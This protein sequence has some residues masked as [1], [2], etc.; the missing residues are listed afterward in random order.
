MKLNTEICTNIRQNRQ[1]VFFG[2]KIEFNLGELIVA[3]ATRAHCSTSAGATHSDNTNNNTNNTNNNTNNTNNTNNNTKNNKQSENSGEQLR[4]V[5]HAIAVAA[6]LPPA[7]LSHVVGERENI[8]CADSLDFDAALWQRSVRCGAATAI[9]VSIGALL[10]LRGNLSVPLA[11]QLASAVCAES[12]RRATF[13]AGCVCVPMVVLTSHLAFEWF[14]QHGR[15]RT[16][17]LAFAESESSPATT[18]GNQQKQKK[19]VEW[20]GKDWFEQTDESVFSSVPVFTNQRDCEQYWAELLCAK[21]SLSTMSALTNRSDDRRRATAYEALAT[22]MDLM[23]RG[24]APLPI[25]RRLIVA[26]V[27][28]HV[29]W[30]VFAN[31]ALA[32]DEFLC[33][34][35]GRVR[36]VPKSVE[37]RLQRHF[38]FGMELFDEHGDFLGGVRQFHTDG[39]KVRNIGPL[40]NHSRN[41][42][43]DGE[44]IFWHGFIIYALFADRDIDKGE[45]L[46]YSYGKHWCQLRGIDERELLTDSAPL[47]LPAFLRLP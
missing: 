27:S 24:Q 9:D 38:A 22:Q 32:Q 35:V 47:S 25:D 39:E 37:E 13:D 12:S 7:I 42:N 4:Q 2:F 23:Y 26:R 14:E 33:V 36:A 19:V 41:C 8:N 46:V 45:Q 3:F 28:E 20:T 6:N 31:A 43:C 17:A 15:E 16:V 30:G 18:N 21:L 40:L 5:L 44:W 29:G 11:Q 10:C 34:Y 1:I